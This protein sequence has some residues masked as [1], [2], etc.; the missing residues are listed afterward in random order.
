MIFPQNDRWI[1]SSSNAKK[2]E[3]VG[4][5]PSPMVLAEVNRL[6]SLTR[7]VAR[8]RSDWCYD[9]D[10]HNSSNYMYAR[11]V[12]LVTIATYR[13]LWWL[14]RSSLNF[15]GRTIPGPR[16]SPTLP[17]GIT[18]PSRGLAAR[19][20][21]RPYRML[22]CS[23]KDMCYSISLA[24]SVSA[25]TRRSS[26]NPDG[27]TGSIKEEW[28]WKTSCHWSCVFIFTQFRCK[29]ERGNHLS[30]VWQIAATGCGTGDEQ[31]TRRTGKASVCSLL[32]RD[33]SLLVK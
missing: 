15:S 21:W 14:L 29:A 19:T 28:F 25:G 30:K 20:R 4:L 11:A 1:S 22:N 10:H 3:A 16:S 9:P 31:R 18:S 8:N 26:L 2:T 24:L 17:T 13:Y 32:I 23:N 7:S 33:L 27:I 12:E 5:N 6:L